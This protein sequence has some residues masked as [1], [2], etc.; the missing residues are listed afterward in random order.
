MISPSSEAEEAEEHDD[1]DKEGEAPP[2]PTPSARKASRERK[3]RAS[4]KKDIVPAFHIRTS[5]IRKSLSDL[6]PKAE[7]MSP[8]PE[9]FKRRKQAYD[10]DEGVFSF[11]LLGCYSMIWAVADIRSPGSLAGLGCGVFISSRLITSKTHFIV[12]SFPVPSPGL[13]EY[14]TSIRLSSRS[15]LYICFRYNEF[16]HMLSIPIA[17]HRLG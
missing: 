1:N 17:D 4:S 2:T 9:R 7:P 3:T 6:A 12:C 11:L 13:Y 16:V 10:S 15:M 5:S 14:P 8:T